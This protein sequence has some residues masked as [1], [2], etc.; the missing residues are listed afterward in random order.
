MIYTGAV[1]KLLDVG[2]NTGKWAIASANF[3]PDIQITIVDLPGQLEMAKTK[4]NQLNLSSRI[5][6]LPLNNFLTVQIHQLQLFL[7]YNTLY[8]LN[9]YLVGLLTVGCLRLF[10]N[11]TFYV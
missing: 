2:G 8:I 10:L 6:L 5:N 11:K 9:G 4:I 1:K 3:S 7:C